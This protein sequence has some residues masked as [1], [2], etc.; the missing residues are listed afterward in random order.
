MLLAGQA[1]N[2]YVVPPMAMLPRPLFVR[3]FEIP[4]N[5]WVESHSH[6]WAQFTYATAGVIEIDTPLGRH[7]LPPHYA[8]WIPPDMP[9]AVSTR[10]CVAFHSLY[11]D[12]AAFGAHPPR[13]GAMLCVT[14]LLRELVAATAEL[15]VD[16]DMSGPDGALV[17]LIM[18][19]I[20][21][22][23]AAPLSV[24]MPSDTRLLKIARALHVDPGDP[25]TLDDWAGQVGATRRTLSRLFRQDTGLSFVEWR[26]ALRLLAAL[27][28]LEA[29]TA[30]S[31]VAEQ[32]GYTSVSAFIAVFQSRFQVTPGVFA[33]TRQLEGKA[34]LPPALPV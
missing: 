18:D 27:L 28:L 2:A 8:M 31:V 26:Q 19:R 4:G 16:Y 21:R 11:L 20:R 30:V 24:P 33:R 23:R 12:A 17:C 9:H 10:E 34:D 5:G 29:G 3:A 15:P 25:R 14:P 22:L 6:P 13:A 7:L 32:L 1:R